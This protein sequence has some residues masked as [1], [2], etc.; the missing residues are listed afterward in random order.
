MRLEGKGAIVT[1]AF[2][3]I[4]R[5]IAELFA[6]EGARIVV[7]D[8]NPELL[9][10]TP[11]GATL[12]VVCDVSD[13]SQVDALARQAQQAL[14]NLDIL[15]NSAGVVVFGTCVDGSEE[16]WD[17]AF[18][19]NAKGVWLMCRMALVRM[20]V[21]GEGVIVNVASATGLRVVEGLAA[22]S[23]SK[24]AVIS[25]TRSIA[26]EYGDRGIRANCICPGRIDT[27]M[28]AVAMEYRLAHGQR[29]EDEF[30][31]YALRRLGRPEEVAAAALYLASSESSYVTGATLP[32]DAGRSL[33]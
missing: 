28:N 5:I 10:D 16:D 15:V 13:A 4:G 18:A 20:A 30:S 23:A 12:P 1:G 32:V 6:A 7:V 29:P 27:P 21:R 31:G 8:R 22:Y 3:G 14:G 11:R 25:L 2:S 26:L 33:H 24:A 19:V 17:R 9:A